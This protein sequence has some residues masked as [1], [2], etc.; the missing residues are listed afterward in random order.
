MKKIIEKFPSDKIFAW[1]GSGNSIGVKAPEYI[2]RYESDHSKNTWDYADDYKE[3]L[4]MEPYKSGADN[5]IHIL[6]LPLSDFNLVRALRFG[7]KDGEVSATEAIGNILA[8]LNKR[9]GVLSDQGLKIFAQAASLCNNDEGYN[10]FVT[11]M[12]KQMEAME[13]TVQWI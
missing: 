9:S 10:D 8:V 1:D 3:A 11:L 12:Y 4:N 13:S 6:N 2:I 7:C 5:T